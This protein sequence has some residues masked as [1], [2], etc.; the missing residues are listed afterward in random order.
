MN[1]FYTEFHIIIDDIFSLITLF[2]LVRLQLKYD[3][4]MIVFDPSVN[5]SSHF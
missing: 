1:T 5:I 3:I 2:V 4:G